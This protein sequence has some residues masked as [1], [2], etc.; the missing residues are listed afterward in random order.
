MTND[1]HNDNNI[2]I[3]DNNEGH[4]GGGQCQYTR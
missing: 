3:N 1:S 4:M 2:Y